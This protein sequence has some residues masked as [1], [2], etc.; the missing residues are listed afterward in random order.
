VGLAGTVRPETP[1]QLAVFNGR[2]SDGTWVLRLVDDSAGDLGALHCATLTLTIQRRA[3]LGV[4]TTAL[5]ATITAPGTI[6]FTD[7]VQNNGPDPSEPVTVQDTLPPGTTLVA[8]SASSGACSGTVPVQCQLS[9]IP[10]GGNASVTVVAGVAAAGTLTNDVKVDSTGLDAVT[11]NNSASTTATATAAATAPSG[12]SATTVTTVVAPPGLAPTAS[13][14]PRALSI[15]TTGG[16]LKG[17][18]ASVP[19]TCTQATACTGVLQLDNQATG[20]VAAASALTLYG[21]AR[22]SV[23]AGQT[24]SVGVR[25]NAAGRRRLGKRVSATV[26]ANATVGGQAVSSRVTLKRAGK[27]KRKR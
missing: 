22:F 10:S 14:P 5:P 7:V 16:T 2:P 15:A 25:L 9:F 17:S 24:K 27:P 6:T 18:T 4:T 19:L 21:S 20:S 12:G 8:A 3:E 11:A 26:F 1:G 23:A 13:A